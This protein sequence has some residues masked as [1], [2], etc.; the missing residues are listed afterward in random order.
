MEKKKVS[1]TIM[2]TPRKLL[3]PDNSG[4]GNH[5]TMVIN[6]NP[7]IK[8][9]EYIQ[10]IQTNGDKCIVQK[11]EFRSLM[12]MIATEEELVDLGKQQIETVRVLQI[13][14]EIVC[15]RNYRKGETVYGLAHYKF[16]VPQEI[17]KRDKSRVAR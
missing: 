3:I 14:V 5:I 1:S 9:C 10:L 16:S 7:F 8:D 6:W 11:D 4:N 12:M 13:P 17:V 15:S 2:D